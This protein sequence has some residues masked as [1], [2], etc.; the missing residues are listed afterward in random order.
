M[1]GNIWK[2]LKLIKL[3]K[4]SLV[5]ISLF[6]VLGLSTALPVFAAADW[7][8]SVVGGILGLIVSMVGL[9]LVLAIKALIYVAQYSTFLDSGAVTFGWVIVRDLCN[10]FFVVILLIIA[11]GTILNLEKYNYKKWLPKLILMAVLINFSKTICGV[12]IDIAQVV[13]LTFVNS[14]SSIGAGTLINVLG[15]TDILQMAKDNSDVSPW[16]VV[17]AYL[18]ALAYVVVSSI[19]IITMIAMLAVRIVM[20]WIYVVLSPLAY[21]LSAF[22]GGESYASKWWSDFTKNLIVGPVLAFFLWLSFAALTADQLKYSQEEAQL[23]DDATKK[24]QASLAGGDPNASGVMGTK[25]SSPSALIKFV[26]AIGMLVGGLKIAQEVGGAAGSMA[27]KGMAAVNKA[28]KIG[29]AG[30]AAVTGARYAQGVY[31]NYAATRK[32][33][34]EDRYKE[35]AVKMAGGIGKV[36]DSVGK[37]VTGGLQKV[38]DVTFGRA[39]AKA[40]KL[41]EEAGKE[42][43][44]ADMI[45]Q[46]IDQKSGS[47]GDYTYDQDLKSWRHSKTGI[48]TGEARVQ[49]KA[50]EII[51]E[52]K[53]IAKGKITQAEKKEEKQKI[54]DKVVKYG[55]LAAGGAAGVIMTGGLGGLALAGAGAVGISRGYDKFKNAG[56]TDL[57]TGSGYRLKEIKKEKEDLK[58][59]DDKNVLAQMD[60]RTVSSFERAAAALEAMERGLLSSD[61]AQAK[62]KMIMDEVGGAEGGEFKDKKVGSYFE[63]IAQRKNISASSDFQDLN[64]TNPEVKDKAEKNIRAKIENGT[65]GLDNLDAGAITAIGPQL[66]A[67]MKNKDF[68]AQFSAMKD[69]GKKREIVQMLQTQAN[70]D[71]SK[72]KDGSIEKNNAEM[73]KLDAMKKLNQV[74]DLNTA[75]AGQ[76]DPLSAKKKIVNDMS[77]TQL[78]DIF[79]G[80]DKTQ[81]DA[82][83]AL[84]TQLKAT[85]VLTKEQKDAGMTIEEVI[86]NENF[87]TASSI[88]NNDSPTSR[89]LKKAMGLIPPS[90]AS[91]SQPSSPTTSQ[92]TPPVGGFAGGAS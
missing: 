38:K 46:S 53:D 50:N 28:G 71:T 36:K 12:L 77:E 83:K 29:L 20:I 32:S 35:A 39:G 65:Y 23:V 47:V 26:I 25:A 73:A 52:K 48:I 55:A 85:T 7:V 67:L 58:D 62:R 1:K 86:I 42:T 56:K 60:D 13:M 59:K 75:T 49:E 79:S 81:M 31:K 34:R 76:A 82:F 21:L 92:S 40:R 72:M 61:Q 5:F 64:S 91:P 33:A 11:F 19:V 16:T 45:Q 80:N 87:S 66:V 18:L 37:G 90:S 30:A 10:M 69:Q 4:K 84:V 14:F 6:V 68:G 78:R 88:L 8:I 74:K 43:E 24:E 41:R 54:I 57:A 44:E 27:G 22:P 70:V 63:S 17:G 51:K 9:I 2:K 89:G 3:N 15:L